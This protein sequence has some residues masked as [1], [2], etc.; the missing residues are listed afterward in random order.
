M[1]NIVG[2]SVYL[3][4]Y[5]IDENN[6]PKIDLNIEYKVYKCDTGTLIN[7]GYLNNIG[8][9]FYS[10][11]IIFSEVGQYRV[12]YTP[13]Q[14]FPKQAETIVIESDI[15]KQIELGNWKIVGTQMIFYNENNIEIAKFNLYDNNGNLTSDM[16]KV[17]ERRRV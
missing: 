9:G 14:N 6:N 16:T 13:D 7:Q 11:D 1:N 3:E 15:I 10:K 4:M 8:E 5:V 12:L 17:V 2:N